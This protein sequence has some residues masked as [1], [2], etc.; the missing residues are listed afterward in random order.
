MCCV[1]SGVSLP[2]SLPRSL[3]LFGG[4]AGEGSYYFVVALHY[5]IAVTAWSILSVVV[6]Q[7]LFHRWVYT[8]VPSVDHAKLSRSVFRHGDSILQVRRRQMQW[9]SSSDAQASMPCSTPP[10][11]GFLAQ[12]LAFQDVH[13]QPS[14]MPAVPV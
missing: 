13:V 12:L 3:S 2:P 9:F 4:T 6:W 11:R 14:A 5:D 8:D 7:Q 10:S 1:A